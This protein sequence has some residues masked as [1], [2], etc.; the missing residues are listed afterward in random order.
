MEMT[1]FPQPLELESVE[2][3]NTWMLSKADTLPGWSVV[4]SFDQTHGKGRRGRVWSSRPGET[5]A[6]SILVPGFPEDVSGT[7]VPLLA[8]CSLVRVLK[9]LGLDVAQVKWP[10]DILVG[11][12]KLSGT[13]V[14]QS[15]RGSLVVGIGINLFSSADRLPHPDAT[16]LV[17][18][19]V[20]I[21]NPVDSLVGPVRGSLRHLIEEGLALD[22]Q[23][24]VRFWSVQVENTLGTI[25]KR[26][27]V[28][29]DGGG[30]REGTAEGLGPSGELRVRAD[31]GDSFAVHAGDVFYIPRS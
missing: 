26:I 11:P 8:G 6:M 15:I 14:E 20:D 3:T 9:N 17:I 5:L 16:S 22:P 4:Y 7:W 30:L 21:A 31:D 23:G 12:R 25:G 18:E 13:L 28:E 2:S 27:S 19:G 10:N 24:C 29:G 1:D